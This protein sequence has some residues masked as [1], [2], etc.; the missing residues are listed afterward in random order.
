MA[1]ILLAAT[2][3]PGHVNPMLA[4]AR[5]LV[6][7]GHR[8]LMLCGALFEQRIRDTGAEFVPFAPEVDFDYRALERHFPERASLSGTAQMALALKR[9]FAAPM[10][11]H[12]RQ[13]RA[14]I[15]AEGVDL[16]L[17]ENGF[18][19]VLPLLQQPHGRPVPILMLGVNP[20]SYSS[21]DAIFYGPRIP[22]EL[23]RSLGELPWL[24]EPTRQLQREVQQRFDAALAEAGA[25]PLTAPFTDVMVTAP[26][27]FLQLSCAG[28]EYERPELEGVI[29]YVGPLQPP[30]LE[31]TPPPWWE[32][33]D[34]RPL[35]IVSQGTLANVDLGQLLLPAMQ[36][37]AGDELQL[38]LTTGGRDPALLGYAIPANAIVTDHVPFELAL[39]RA[40]A[41]VTNG[42][43]GSVQSALA[44][45]VPLVVAG[46][47]EDKAEVATRVAWSGAGIN[48][49]CNEPTAAMVATAVRKVV[50]EPRYRARARLLAE[51]MAALDGRAAIAASVADLLGGRP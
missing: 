19:G 21:P 20:V 11:Q 1:T 30:R 39:P 47:G 51:E 33:L 4:V 8:V 6:A 14:L 9:F 31:L 36:G 40:A 50:G 34:E 38:L 22:P 18:Y 5:L 48:L 49:H 29:R 45:G 28:F 12:D 44:H 42:G 43:Y 15:A 24:D 2:A 41:L 3:T 17:V 10:A 7:Q 46:T 26:D 32:R 16:L 27:A 25:P 35:V 37:L 23:R 13:L